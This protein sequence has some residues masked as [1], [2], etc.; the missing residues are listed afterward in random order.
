MWKS[1][2]VLALYPR[3][4]YV[5]MRTWD[6]GH[7][8]A[9]TLSAH[10]VNIS[11]PRNHRPQTYSARHCANQNLWWRHKDRSDHLLPTPTQPLTLLQDLIYHIDAVWCTH[12]KCWAPVPDVFQFQVGFPRNESRCCILVM[13]MHIQECKACCTVYVESCGV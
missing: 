10:M 3:P 13:I 1:I 6:E 9:H 2:S 12:S 5:G 7:E 4:S 8:W 11:V